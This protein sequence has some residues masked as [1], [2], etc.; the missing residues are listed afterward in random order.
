MHGS[1]PKGDRKFH[2]DIAVGHGTKVQVEILDNCAY[3]TVTGNAYWFFEDNTPVGVEECDS[4][5]ASKLCEMLHAL[6]AKH[7]AA[8]KSSPKDSTADAHEPTPIRLLG[9]LGTSKYD[10]F[11]NGQI[12][13]REPFIMSN[14]IGELEYPS[15]SEADLAFCTVLAVYH[16]GDAAKVDEEYR[17]SPLMRPKWERK[18]YR[19]GTI[20]K[21]IET[22]EK[23]KAEERTR[24]QAQPRLLV[25]ENS[26]WQYAITPE[27]YEAE[28]EKEFPVIPLKITA[29]PEWDDGIMHGV[30]GDIIRKASEYCEAHPAGMYLDF[31]VSFGS[32]VGR[33]P[34]FNVNS[35]QHRANEFMVRVGDSAFS[36]KGTGRDFIDGLL[37]LVDA[38]WYQTRVASGFGSAEAIIAEVRDDSQQSVRNKRKNVFESVLVP[39]VSDK[40]LMIREPELASLFRL[41]S[42]PQSFA[43]VVIRNAWDG[44]PLRNLVKGKS[45]GLSN[46]NSCQFPHISISADTTGREFI[47]ELPEGADSNGFGNRFLYCYVRRVKLCPNGGP[48]ID[49][50]RELV[51]VHEALSF[52]RDLEYIGVQKSASK[53]W[54]RMYGEIEDDIQRV[55]GLAGA[56][57]ARAV[58]HVRRLAL[59]L[60]L[61]DCHDMIET[62][63][64]HAAKRIWDY[65]QDS[66]RFIF[67][68]TTAEQERILA[69]MRKQHAPVTTPQITQQLFHKNKKSEWVR[70]HVNALVRAGKIV[71]QGEYLAVKPSK[72][73]AQKMGQEMEK[74]MRTKWGIDF[75]M[76]NAF[77][78]K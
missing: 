25:D 22:A 70:L 9:T 69:W 56:M 29:G 1:I 54:N 16:D 27:E 18:D 17:Q 14:R 32:M 13:R 28:M 12:E 68:G 53:V 66:A 72:T 45:D 21:A 44:K 52:G 34:Y 71:V 61:L 59:I 38:D 40:R 23:L 58:A 62:H 39:G 33:G 63:H 19:E 31:L 6:R 20:A 46:S 76:R 15:Q 48:Q 30:A 77:R 41:A 10:I 37:K 11:T 73:A 75:Q 50:T 8:S 57:C 78:E 42:K 35:T 51:R 2:F 24:Q 5:T 49:W 64:L 65:C 4:A 47:R 74:T 3:G 55:P 67:S 7:P 26:E 60:C 36:R 43:D